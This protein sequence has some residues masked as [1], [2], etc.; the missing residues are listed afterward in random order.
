MC[1]SSTAQWPTT[2][3]VQDKY[4]TIRQYTHN[5]TPQKHTHKQENKN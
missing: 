4:N 2:K 5:N 3:P 1:V